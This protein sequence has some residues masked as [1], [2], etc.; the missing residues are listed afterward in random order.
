MRP[1]LQVKGVR[2]Y[3]DQALNK[4]PHG[5]YTP[6]HCDGFYWPVQSDKIVT[7]W[8]P[9][10]V[11]STPAP[12]SKTLPGRSAA[13]LAVHDGEILSGCCCCCYKMLYHVAG[14]LLNSGMCYVIA[15]PQQWLCS[16]PEAAECV[17]QDVPLEMGPLQFAVGSHQHDLGRSAAA[18]C[19]FCET[20][21]MPV[22]CFLFWREAASIPVLL[23]TYHGIAT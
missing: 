20:Q 2:V 10:Q 6:W 13:R 16:C 14:S 23:M 4:E 17:M 15:S 7:A 5:G 11:G 9:L 3:H 22:T 8:I 12:L 19:H 21:T 1:C 18:T